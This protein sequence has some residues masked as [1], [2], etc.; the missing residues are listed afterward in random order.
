MNII[1]FYNC[2][3]LSEARQR[4]QEHF[5]ALNATLNSV[6]PFP[7]KPVRTIRIIKPVKQ[8]RPVRPNKSK[9]NKNM[10]LS[11]HQ[12]NRKY[13]YKCEPCRYY[14]TCRRDY[15]RHLLTQKH[16]DGGSLASQIVKSSDGYECY[17]CHNVFK[18]RTSI[19]KHISN[20][21]KSSSQDVNIPS[22][23]PT[24]VHDKNIISTNDNIIIT[25]EMF[26]TLLKSNQEMISMLRDLYE[27]RNMTNNTTNN[28]NTINANTTNNNSFNMNL[29]IDEQ[30]KDLM[31]MKD[32]VN[33][34]QLNMAD[35]KNV[36][37][38][39]GMPNIPN[40]RK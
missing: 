9:Y 31:D 38:V 20:C 13:V 7:S 34:V 35:L 23:P 40:F 39:E 25:K 17:C 19:Y 30:S 10:P 22:T 36:D 33:S 21:S 1:A 29:Y 15:D 2:K 32:F 12:M 26:M 18:S 16:L 24:N 37:S 28:T 27:K 4:E 11:N 3:D 5:V 14:T 8:V 6:E